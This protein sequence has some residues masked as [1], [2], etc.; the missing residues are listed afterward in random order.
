MDTNMVPPRC[1][2]LTILL[3]ILTLVSNLASVFVLRY[4]PDD[5]LHLAL[6]IL[7]Y[8]YFAAGVSL[9]GLIGACKRNS[10][11]I[12]VF[13]N[14]L[15]LD[16]ILC[17]I[18]RVVVM[19]FLSRIWEGF[20]VDRA[21]VWFPSEQ[22]G[23]NDRDATLEQ[24]RVQYGAEQ[25]RCMK[26]LWGVQAAVTVAAVVTT[27]AQWSLAM[28]IRLYAKS[29][30]RR[31]AVVDGKVEELQHEPKREVFVERSII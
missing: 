18:P 3:S 24:M 16:A 12:T 17:M 14:H 29:L 4:V 10:A 15:L 27:T 19:I 6:R 26:V 13:A 22:S 9:L 5:S 31:D 1:R 2:H 25:Q 8:S 21:S 23:A 11:L 30:T 28:R 20:C 7:I